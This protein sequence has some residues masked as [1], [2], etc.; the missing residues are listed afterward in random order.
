MNF[1]HTTEQQALY[2][3]Y[4]RKG[5]VFTNVIQQMEEEITRMRERKVQQDFIDKKDLQVE[6]LVSYFNAVDDIINYQ[7][8]QIMNL[9]LENHFLTQLVAQKVSLS[10]L[11]AYKP[12]ART[13]KAFFSKPSCS[14]CLERVEV[15]E[16]LSLQPKV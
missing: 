3:Q 14:N 11:I 7:K 5:T 2:A 12:T 13:V 10:E 15:S 8:M 4:V 1:S 6:E 16:K 9:K